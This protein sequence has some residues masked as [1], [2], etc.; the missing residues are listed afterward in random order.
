[1]I[2]KTP[3]SLK[4]QIIKLIMKDKY[5]KAILIISLILNFFLFYKISKTEIMCMEYQ[6][7]IEFSSNEI[8]K[9]QAQ[10]ELEVIVMEEMLDSKDSILFSIR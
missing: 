9:I 10:Y 5:L 2:C 1:M 4:H 7:F 3:I 6:K 8:K